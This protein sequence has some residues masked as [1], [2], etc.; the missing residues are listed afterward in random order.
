MMQGE[1]DPSQ[2]EGSNT[3]ADKMAEASAS[4]PCTSLYSHHKNNSEG[5]QYVA[6]D[7]SFPCGWRVKTVDRF[8]IGVSSPDDQAKFIYPSG[9]LGL[10]DGSTVQGSIEANDQTYAVTWFEGENEKG[11]FVD[12]NIGEN[13][14]DIQLQYQ[15]EEQKTQLE[16]IIKSLKVTTGEINPF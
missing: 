4:E 16:N 6:M 3:G 1:T 9:D 14:Y 12:T 10:H 5:N 15:T 2:D 13:K 8:E 7:F 11:A